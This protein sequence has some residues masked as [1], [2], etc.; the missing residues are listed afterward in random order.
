[1]S[2]KTSVL[3]PAELEALIVGGCFFG[4]GGGG[5]L[6][7]AKSLLRHFRVGDYYPT[8][9]V[10]VIPAESATEGDAVVVAYMGAPAKLDT[11]KYPVGPA[12]AVEKVMQRLSA[13]GR[14]LK[15][16]VPPESGALGFLVACLV[17]AK[18]DLAVVDADGAGRAVPSLPMLT[19]AAEGVPPDPAF[20]V[21]QG[22]L[23]VELDVE[24]L[25]SRGSAAHQTEMS[26]IVEHMLRPII[27]EPQFG[28]FGGLAT[29]IMDPPLLKQALK[30]PGTLS[31]A[32]AFGKKIL[33][34]EI[35]SSKGIFAF[36]EEHRLKGFSLFSDGVLHA[37]SQSSVGGF[38]LGRI[39][40]ARGHRRA[41]SLYQNESLIAWDS[42][43]SHPLAMAP[44]SIAYF[45]DENPQR[46]VSNGDLVAADGSLLP[47]FQGTKVTLI[48][49]TA[50]PALRVTHG[51]AQEGLILRSFMAQLK[52]MGYQGAYVPVEK[53]QAEAGEGRR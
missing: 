35:D 44:D 24:S 15:Y 6:T 18:Y 40:I 16:I 8:D 21:S 17:A 36:L 26:T 33:S 11:A 50:D 39:E 13:Q 7:S 12:K 28:Q 53:L 45:L 43:L 25:D 19:F 1:M 30:V 42:A 51:P 52:S 38:D 20:V 48:G 37:A 5:T 49:V 10:K 9:Q 27:S 22:G 47:K 32:L 2:A 4:S 34:G 23:A 46:V 41:I 29:W 14:R 31:R 3:N